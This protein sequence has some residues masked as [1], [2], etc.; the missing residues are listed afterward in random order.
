VFKIGDKVEIFSEFQDTV[1]ESFTWV[2]IGDEEIGRVDISPI[3]IN[4]KIKPVYT[5]QAHWIRLIS[6]YA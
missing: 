4:M 5:A 2:V 6:T 1:D 3:D